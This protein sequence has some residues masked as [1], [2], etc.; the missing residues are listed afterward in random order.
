[1]LLFSR[2]LKVDQNAT[3][4]GQTC[5]GFNDKV[6]NLFLLASDGFQLPH[7]LTHGQI[8][9]SSLDHN[10]IGAII[11]DHAILWA[12]LRQETFP[13]CTTYLFNISTRGGRYV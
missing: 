7:H 4:S 2:D 6:N 10:R 8:D 5:K 11:E 3:G 13:G 1:M 12:A 9:G